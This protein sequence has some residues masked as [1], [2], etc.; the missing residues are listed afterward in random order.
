MRWRASMDCLIF[1]FNRL[2]EAS[3]GYPARC[4]QGAVLAKVFQ[5]FLPYPFSLSATFHQVIVDV[6]LNDFV[7]DIRHQKT[8][9]CC[10]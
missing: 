8:V 2:G 10:A 6:A 5:D 4:A 7:P 9:P 3:V 1:I